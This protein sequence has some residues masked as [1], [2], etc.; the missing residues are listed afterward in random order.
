MVEKS[1]RSRFLPVRSF[2]I[3]TEPLSEELL[4]VINPH[5]LAVCDPNFLLEYF[6]LSADKRLLFGNRFRYLGEDTA[7]IAANHR[8]RML[9]TYPQLK[10]VGIDYAWG[11]TIAIPINRV[12]QLGRIAPNV[13]YSKG[14][15]NNIEIFV[16]YSF[17]SKMDV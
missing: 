9:K 1:L 5:D 4:D 11:G 7:V 15:N 2:I 17:V 16:K 13:L 12:P 6:R 8:P 14:F 3:A 10:D